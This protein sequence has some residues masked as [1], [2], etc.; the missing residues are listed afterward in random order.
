MED[1]DETRPPPPAAAEA[2]EQTSPVSTV[3]LQ[4]TIDQPLEAIREDH[5]NSGI[6]AASCGMLVSVFGFRGRGHSGLLHSGFSKPECRLVS[7]VSVSDVPRV[8]TDKDGG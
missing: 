7:L 4:S 3:I 6:K 2:G 5:Y 8:V 1:V